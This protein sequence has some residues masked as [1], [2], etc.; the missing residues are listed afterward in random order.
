M[1]PER[2]PRIPTPFRISSP[3]RMPRAANDNVPEN[4]ASMAS[5]FVGRFVILVAL[6][7]ALAIMLGCAV[8]FGRTIW[9][10]LT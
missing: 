4:P 7:A 3:A 2:V 5:F 1:R 9:R 6:V 10:L 8:W